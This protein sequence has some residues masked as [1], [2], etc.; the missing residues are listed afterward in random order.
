L[1]AP[2][3]FGCI[4]PVAH[5][6]MD[7]V[8]RLTKIQSQQIHSI[9]NGSI[10]AKRREAEFAPLRAAAATAVNSIRSEIEAMLARET[11]IK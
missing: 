2:I 11:H 7:A 5:Q 8:R 1:S 6:E 3:P 10:A 4:S 9:E